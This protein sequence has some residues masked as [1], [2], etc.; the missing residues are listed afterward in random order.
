M[1]CDIN[2]RREAAEARALLDQLLLNRNAELEHAT[3]TAEKANLAKS[4]FL[5]SMSH[6]LRTPLNAI[7]GFAQILE[8]DAVSPAAQKRSVNQILQAGWYLLDLINEILDLAL[9]ESGKLSVSMESVSIDEVLRE[10]RTMI[11]PQALA[12]RINLH[13][14]ETETLHYVNVDRTRLKQIIIN[15]LSNAIKY[16]KTLGSVVVT[17]LR[18]SPERIRI[19]VED[20]GEGLSPEK[21]SQLFQPFNRLGQESK[22]VEGTGI[23]LVMTK[24][25]CELMGGR[26][27]VE[28]V[29]GKGS[30]FWIEINLTDKPT[31]TSDKDQAI[32]TI[33]TEVQTDTQHTI[34]YVEDNP[35][36]VMLVENIISRCSN[37]RLLT[38]KDANAGIQMAR[39]VQPSVI[40]MDINLSGINGIEAVKILALDPLTAHIPVVAVSANALPRDIEKCMELGFFRYLTKPFNINT[41]MSTIDDA[42]AAATKT[43]I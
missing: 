15:L 5:S 10:C 21:I 2:D 31:P 38:A 11:E 6:E 29:V 13:F 23:G 37:L 25:L 32:A 22:G 26:I 24:R 17:C 1:L 20:S 12:Q 40:L 43:Q 7:L 36:N 4:D 30:V 14:P 42:L 39:E 18:Q 41:L 16:N 3:K 33:E 28:S 27:G 34:V 8:G 35:A 19:C 9:I